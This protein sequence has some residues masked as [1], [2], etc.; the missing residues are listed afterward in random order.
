MAVSYD[1]SAGANTI[2]PQ[3]DIFPFLRLP[4]ELRDQIYHHVFSLAD[5]RSHRSLRIERRNLKIFEPSP[6]SIL[7]ILH[8]EALLLSRQTAREALEVLF[9]HH[10]V[11]FSCGPFVLKALLER[12]ERDN[13]PGRVW[14]RWIKH[15]ELDWVTFPNMR[16][17]P[18]E[19]EDGRD[20][21]WYWEGEEG[22]QQ[23]QQQQGRG[24]EVY[25]R[26]EVDVD[27]IRGAATAAASSSSSSAYNRGHYDEY[28]H[29][30]YHYDDNF[31]DPDDEV[32]LYP[33][34]RRAYNHTNVDNIN[35][36]FGLAHHDPFIDPTR[37][38]PR[39][40]SES[41]SPD[42]TATKL[43]LLISLEV[44]PLFTYL[45]SP[46]FNLVTLTLPLYFVSK[47]T[48]QER[49]LTRPGFALP[50]KIRYWVQVCVH[51]LLMLA[52]PCGAG[53]QRVRVRYLP[54]DVWA[55]L[56]PADDLARMVEKG[57]WFDGEGEG[58]GQGGEREGE[59]EA[60]R[61]VWLGM[62]E[63]GGDAEEEGK[64][65]MGLEAH[66][67]MVPWDGNVD[68]SWVGDELEVVFTRRDNSQEV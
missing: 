35:D 21:V 55:S 5:P 39:R 46:T 50:L 24:R 57:V 2:L 12:I 3:K 22:Q 9:K 38:H 23:Q 43:D 18:P 37:P 11:F 54:W 33:S 1:D 60:F 65:R 64:K 34:F 42:E 15:V 58:Q 52:R 61:S 62:R 31:Y 7:L 30:G 51:A 29:D 41:A 13:G 48:L 59:G 27:Y 66:V 63:R 6:A 45:A 28:D 47:Q 25:D 10:T 49:S 67:R 40:N 16:C 26:E 4:R 14:L 36:P 56:E 20:A 44:T 8:H 17:Y 53:L 68:S 32:A 19:R